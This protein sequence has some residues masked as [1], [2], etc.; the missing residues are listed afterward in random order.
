MTPQPPP[1]GWPVWRGARMRG[2]WPR[3]FSR[4]GGSGSTHRGVECQVVPARHS[5]MSDIPRDVCK[6][7]L[8]HFRSGLTWLKMWVK[9]HPSPKFCEGDRYC[10]FGV[11]SIIKNTIDLRMLLGELRHIYSGL[12]QRGWG[13]TVRRKPGRPHSPVGTEAATVAG[14][15]LAPPRRAPAS[16][17]CGG[18]QR[19]SSTA[20]GVN[21]AALPPAVLRVGHS[22]APCMAAAGGE[23]DGPARHTGGSSTALAMLV[24]V[25]RRAA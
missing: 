12:W 5:P 14:T 23:R 24:C 10:A 17:H 19:W 11:E 9:L 16:H 13:R 25:G 8:F 3:R 4:Q 22:R 21:G 15:A 1:A 18:F 6:I 2:K 20:A 7:F